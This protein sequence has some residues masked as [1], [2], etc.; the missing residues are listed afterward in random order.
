MGQE[1]ILPI[2]DQHQPIYQEVQ[3]VVTSVISMCVAGIKLNSLETALPLV[4]ELHGLPC[5]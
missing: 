4:Q 3:P 2:R 1:R 5:L